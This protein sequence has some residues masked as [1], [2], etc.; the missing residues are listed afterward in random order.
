MELVQF[1]WTVTSTEQLLLK[2]AATAKLKCS[3]LSYLYRASVENLYSIERT[4]QY[5]TKQNRN[6][7]YRTYTRKHAAISE[8]ASLSV[9]PTFFSF[10]TIES[11]TCLRPHSS[12][13]ALIWPFL[14]LCLLPFFFLFF[15]SL[16]LLSV[17]PIFPQPFR[18]P[19]ESPDATWDCPSQLGAV[20]LLL[21]SC[22]FLTYQWTRKKGNLQQRNLTNSMYCTGLPHSMNS[23]E[24]LV[25]ESERPDVKCRNQCTVNSK[26]VITLW[27]ASV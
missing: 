8:E 6:N 2:F 27:Q 11:R 5:S 17:S 12:P 18:T 16:F 9:S 14:R 15:L 1:R 7:L 26:A 20:G 25:G 22:G 24:N 21:L 4:V 3:I 23:L 13:A 19:P 10:W